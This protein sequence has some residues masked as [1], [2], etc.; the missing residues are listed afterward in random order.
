MK[1]TKK[2]CLIRQIGLSGYASLRQ[3]ESS[4]DIKGTL[5]KKYIGD[6]KRLK[7]VFDA[8]RGYYS[9]KREEYEIIP[10]SRT[11]AIIKLIKKKFPEIRFMVWNTLELQE[12]YEHTQTKGVTIIETEKDAVLPVYEWIHR[13][14]R[15]AVVGKKG[16]K[17]YEEVR[18]SSK[19]VILRVLIERAPITGNRPRMEKLII[20]IDKDIER[21]GYMTREDYWEMCRE[22]EKRYKVRYG[23]LISYLRRKKNYTKYLRQIMQRGIFR[24]VINGEKSNKSPKD[25]K[26]TNHER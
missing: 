12:F 19:P 18:L 11:K 2:D 16:K 10:C 17:Y 26:Q 20:D 22:Y 4:C 15:E 25:T 13:N 7:R 9:N 3:I 1:E 5:A 23:D 8:G 14:Y 21:Y 6:L 24:P